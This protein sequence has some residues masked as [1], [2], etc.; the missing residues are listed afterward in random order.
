MVPCCIERCC[1]NVHRVAFFFFVCVMPHINWNTSCYTCEYITSQHDAF[2]CAAWRV[3]IGRTYS[4]GSCYENVATRVWM[5]HVTH[6]NESWRTCARVMSH[7]NTSCHTSERVSPLHIEC[8]LCHTC[9]HDIPHGNY[10]E[11]WRRVTCECVMSHI[12]VWHATHMNAS[13][14]T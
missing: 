8:G 2:T 5:C 9:E 14:H 13:C 1:E 6:A 10:I 12:Q 7:V 11:S 4:V 3:R